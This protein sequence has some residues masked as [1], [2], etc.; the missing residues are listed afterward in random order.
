GLPT[1]TVRGRVGRRRLQ[2]TVTQPAEACVAVPY[3]DPDGATATCT[4]TE[5]A[6]VEV[7]LERRSGGAWAIERR[8]ELDG[9]AHAE[10]GTRP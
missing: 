7:V 6:D 5:R 2:V 10:V 9:T 4:N 8:W 3:T 1:W